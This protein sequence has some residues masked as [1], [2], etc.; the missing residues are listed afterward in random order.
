MKMNELGRT[1]IKVSRLCLGTMT[2]GEQNTEAEG[3]RQM[4]MAVDHGVNF[5]DTAE[6]YS[7]PGKP[8]TQGDSERIIGTWMKA[9]GN[10]A[11]VV[12]ATKISGKSSERSHIR[13]GNLGFGREQ[14]AEAVDLSLQRLQT[15]TIDLY[16]THWPERKSNYFGKLDYAHVEDESLTSMEEQLSALAEQV[17]A[18]KIRAI[19]VCNETAWGVMK[20]LEI[21]ER[22]GLDRISAIQNPYNLLCRQ[23]EVGLSEVSIREDCG[24]LAYSPLGFG[25]LSGKYIGGAAPAG[26]RHVLFPQFMRYFKP[27]GVMATEK[28]VTLAKDH[29]LDP[30]QMALAFVNSQ[31]FLTA[32]IIGATTQEQLAANLASEGM[33][34]SDDVLAGIEA[35][36]TENSNPSP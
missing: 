6:G 4:D 29:G 22:T 12:I 23:F 20:F 25:A 8:E 7:F 27:P 15:D 21:A 2:F 36:H 1:G 5:F 16:Q 10:R 35:L 24:L 31:R 3:H 34:L 9:R 17:K 30:A 32:T 33:V 13:N 28:Y 18:G 14:V 26:S 19:G 11:D